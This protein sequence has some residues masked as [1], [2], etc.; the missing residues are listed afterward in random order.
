MRRRASTVGS[1]LGQR[2]RDLRKTLSFAQEEFAKKAGIG[3]SYLSTCWI[4]R[5]VSR[6]NPLLSIY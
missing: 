4:S 3:A 5:P 2:I 6:S 1:Q